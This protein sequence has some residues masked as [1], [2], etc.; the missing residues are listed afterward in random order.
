MREKSTGSISSI[1]RRNGR[2]STTLSN[3]IW[4]DGV[5][6]ASNGDHPG[7]GANG[8]AS[9]TSGAAMSSPPRPWPESGQT[10][11]STPVTTSCSQ[12]RSAVPTCQT[13][14]T[15]D[16]LLD[17]S[18]RVPHRAR[19]ATHLPPLRKRAC[20]RIDAHGFAQRSFRLRRRTSSPASASRRASGILYL[21][22]NPKQIKERDI[23][24]QVAIRAPCQ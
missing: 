13:Q 14:T 7:P 8:R 3:A 2:P 1:C 4:P 12:A 21:P 16:E 5:P 11:P 6:S 20:P 10:T 23:T 18:S 17:S 22:R 9:R 15:T 19:L 24:N